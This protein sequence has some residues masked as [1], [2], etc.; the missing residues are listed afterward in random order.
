[1]ANNV[2]GGGGEIWQI[3]F[4]CRYR[5]FRI[6]GF[7]LMCWLNWKHHVNFFCHNGHENNQIPPVFN[8]IQDY[9]HQIPLQCRTGSGMIDDLS[10]TPHLQMY[11]EKNHWCMD[12]EERM[13]LQ[14]HMG[15]A[16]GI[17]QVFTYRAPPGRSSMYSK[18]TLTSELTF[19]GSAT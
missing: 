4:L 17:L 19:Y 18:H 11:K 5:K 14:H 9:T 3:H 2:D 13:Q 7:Y 15:E 6:D 1:M 16:V 12:V 8:G 10:T